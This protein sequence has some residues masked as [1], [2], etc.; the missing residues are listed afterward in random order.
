MKKLLTLPVML[1][2]M[3]FPAFASASEIDAICIPKKASATVKSPS[4]V[5]VC[6]AENEKD[7]ALSLEQDKIIEHMTLTEGVGGTTIQVKGVNIQL[8][9]EGT[10]PSG[11]LI[12]GHVGPGE[13]NENLEVQITGSSGKIKGNGNIISG[14]NPNVTGNNSV[15][16]GGVSNSVTSSHSAIVGGK[17]DSA[18][19]T[20][21][22]VF[23]STLVSATKENEALL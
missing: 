19:A 18:T 7:Y 20:N 15:N 12:I 10:G 1:V 21:S 23:G 9:G 6:P 22:S 8:T 5:G 16:I 17:S 2:V 4:A 3:A 13:G 11:N 14:E